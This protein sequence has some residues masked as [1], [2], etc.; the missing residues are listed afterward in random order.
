[1]FYFSIRTYQYFPSMLQGTL[2]SK[3]VLQKPKLMPKLQL[4]S[5]TH[6]LSLLEIQKHISAQKTAC[7]TECVQLHLNQR[8]FPFG[9]LKFFKVPWIWGPQFGKHS[10]IQL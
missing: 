5:S 10:P 8:V 6:Y 7:S 1:M 2:D 4:G 3:D 9:R